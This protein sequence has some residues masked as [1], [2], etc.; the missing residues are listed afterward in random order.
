MALNAAGKPVKILV[1]IGASNRLVVPGIEF[2]SCKM[3]G[4][5]QIK[6]ATPAAADAKPPIPNTQQGLVLRITEIVLM[7]AAS[8]K[9]GALIQ[10]SKFL[11]RTPATLIK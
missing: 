6:A 4:T 7:T 1:A 9:T 8:N 11:P 2:C 10:D 3:S 5:R